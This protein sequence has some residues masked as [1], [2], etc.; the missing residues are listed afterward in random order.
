MD[1]QEE[2]KIFSAFGTHCFLFFKRKPM[3]TL[4]NKLYQAETPR[5]PKGEVSLFIFGRSTHNSH[6]TRTAHFNNGRS[7]S[8]V[9]LIRD[10]KVENIY[11]LL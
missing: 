4:L 11:L 2:Q 9:S 6:P 7:P 10:I 8:S 3:F 1:R 5:R